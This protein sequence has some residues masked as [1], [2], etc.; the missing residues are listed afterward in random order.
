ML[1]MADIHKSLKK[2]STILLNMVSENMMFEKLELIASIKQ[3][4][5]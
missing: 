2:I 5:K 1:G 4:M 3:S